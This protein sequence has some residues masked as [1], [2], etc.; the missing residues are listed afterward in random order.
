MPLQHFT[1]ISIFPELFAIL[2]RYGV[3]ARAIEKNIIKLN[4][5]NPRDYTQDKHA[6]IDDKPFGGGPGMLMKAEPLIA[7]INE[8]KALTP[9]PYIIVYLSPQGQTFKQSQAKELAKNTNL[10]LLCGRYEGIDQRIIE[11]QI[12]QVWSIGDYVLTGGELPAMIVLDTITRL[13][14]KVLGNAESAIKESFTDN[15]LDYPQYTRPQTFLNQSVPE[16]LLSGDHKRIRLWRLKQSLGYTL[17][18]RPEVLAQKKL[19]PQEQ[20]L[21][22]EYIKE[23]EIDPQ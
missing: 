10:I 8:A 1:L 12:H 17:R 6:S 16:I 9:E 21:L 7:A 19:S 11:Q 2:T 5:I 18:F 13:I 4:L 3:T 22:E 15:L 23:S 14:P 20:Q